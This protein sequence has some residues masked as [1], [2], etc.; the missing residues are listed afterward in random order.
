MEKKKDNITEI[1]IHHKNKVKKFVLVIYV[2][3]LLA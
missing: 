2:S 1:N 3:N